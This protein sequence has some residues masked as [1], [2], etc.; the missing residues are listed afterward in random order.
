MGDSLKFLTKINET[1]FFQF[2]AYIHS[3]RRNCLINTEIALK[4]FL[5][6]KD[7]R[8]QYIV[9]L[10]KMSCQFLVFSL[11]K[12]GIFKIQA[13]GYN[14]EK[15]FYCCFVRLVFNQTILM[16][17]TTFNPDLLRWED[18]LLT[19]SHL[20]LA[21]YIKDIEKDASSLCWFSLRFSGKVLLSLASEFTSLVLWHILKAS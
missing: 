19:W 16:C 2:Q 10:Y 8:K 4:W 14:C 15:C 17:R 13:V 21:A 6:L 5:H 11:A 18:I 1:F 20:L 12:S 9:F 3:L 7:K